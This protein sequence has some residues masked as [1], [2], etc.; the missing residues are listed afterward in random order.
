M[1]RWSEGIPDETGYV[2]YGESPYFSPPDGLELVA[3]QDL[4]EESWEFHLVAVWQDDRTGELL[5]VADA[6]CSCPTPFADLT[7]E[8]MKPIRRVEDM[9]SLIEFIYYP[10]PANVSRLRQQ[11]RDLLRV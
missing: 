10:L 3:D 9:D 11:V 8:G 1:T 4:R 7:R 2:R 6:G 5:A